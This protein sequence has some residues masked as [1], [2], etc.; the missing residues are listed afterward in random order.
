M[1]HRAIVQVRGTV[2]MV[3][4]Q[5]VGAPIPPFFLADGAVPPLLHF[6]V[7]PAPAPCHAIGRASLRDICHDH[8]AHNV[9]RSLRPSHPSQRTPSSSSTVHH[10]TAH[11]TTPHRHPP[12]HRPPHLRHTTTTSSQQTLPVTR[13][14]STHLSTTIIK[15][16]T[17]NGQQQERVLVRT[18]G[19]GS[20]PLSQNPAQ[21]PRSPC[22]L[23]WKTPT[24]ATA[25]LSHHTTMA[26]SMGVV[27][28]LDISPNRITKPVD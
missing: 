23:A 22:L 13:A 27:P 11:Q 2:S 3:F 18:T 28:R 19:T 9:P 4:P 17:T 26:Q 12:Y 1:A 20:R 21:A 7:N 14:R 25:F 16:R 6:L 10:R 15:D 5:L 24:I 8:V